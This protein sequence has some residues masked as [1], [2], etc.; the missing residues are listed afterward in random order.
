M[1]NISYNPTDDVLKRGFNTESVSYQRTYYG[2]HGE[3][4][5]SQEPKGY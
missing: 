5:C 1:D 2:M 4:D 3:F